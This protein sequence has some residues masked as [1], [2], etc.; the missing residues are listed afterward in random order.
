MNKIGYCT[1]SGYEDYSKEWY[2]YWIPRW[3]ICFG[4]GWYIPASIVA[5]WR[6]LF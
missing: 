2:F 6:Y 4:L 1:F 3:V 5:L